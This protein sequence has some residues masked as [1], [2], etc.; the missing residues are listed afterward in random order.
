MKRS[1]VTP[2][3][4]EDV[5]LLPHDPASDRVAADDAAGRLRGPGRRTQDLRLARGHAVVA[6][7]E[8]DPAGLH[9]RAGDLVAELADHPFVQLVF[10]GVVAPRGHPRLAVDPGRDDER[11]A[12]CLRYGSVDVGTASDAE[13]A[14]LDDRADTRRSSPCELRRH[15]RDHVSGF[16]LRVAWLVPRP[17]V[18]ED[19]FMGQDQA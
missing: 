15:E 18:D 2:A 14:R 12:R 10:A 13:R 11:E 9:A 19:V 6:G 8:L 16:R 5:E 4:F 7:T 1:G 3:E 17:K